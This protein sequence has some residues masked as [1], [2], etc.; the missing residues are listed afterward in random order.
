MRNKRCPKRDANYLPTHIGRGFQSELIDLVGQLTQD[1]E[2][3]GAERFKRRYLQEKLLSK[4]CDSSTTP[5]EVRRSAAIEKWLKT[6]TKNARTNHRLLV[7]SVDFGWTTSDLIDQKARSIISEVLGPLVY[8]DVL[9]NGTHT[10]GA[11]T[12]VRRGV[13]AAILKHAGQAH[14]SGSALN[15]WSF[16]TLGT[17]IE[18]QPIQIQESSVLFTVGKSSEIDRV[19]CKEP[20]INMFLQRSVGSHIRRRLRRFGVDLNDQTINQR[21]AGSA[22]RD[23]L[24]TIDLSAASDSISIQLVANWLPPEWFVLLNELRVHSTIID[25]TPHELSMFSSM[26][27]GF[28][29]ELE[30]LLFYALTRAVCFYSRA[31]GKISVYGDDIVCP[32][33][34]A[35]RLARVFAWYG[36][37]VN[38]EKSYWTGP[39][40]ESCGKHYYFDVDV[41]PF[42]IREPVTT[43]SDVIRLLNRLLVWDSSESYCLLTEKVVDFHKKWMRIIPE[44]LH[45][46]QDPEDITSLVTGDP[47]RRR[48]SR[49]KG[50]VSYDQ[51]AGL[52]YWLTTKGDGDSVLS[53]T[54]RTEGRFVTSPQP[55]WLRRAKWEPYLVYG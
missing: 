8:P 12:R 32:S 22:V 27:N 14:S 20:E 30:S 39:F 55:P 5:P 46:G 25:G 48:L 19:A 3:K 53:L 35:R 44:S 31:Q 47:P 37:S 1:S 36:F 13:T 7:D 15:H 23:G 6:E 34:V 21:L 11:S 2:P 17:V 33:S 26:G 45:G 4:Y 40:R 41:T 54:P 43:V 29:F 10:N 16:V 18:D 49:R 38:T 51:L 9:T 42:F 24:A 52:H 50:Q 28:T